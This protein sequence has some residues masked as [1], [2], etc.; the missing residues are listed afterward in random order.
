MNKD[1]K[2]RYK[3]RTKNARTPKPP[4]PKP[5]EYEGKMYVRIPEFGLCRMD[6]WGWTP[7]PESSIR[8]ES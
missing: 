2:A 7:V 3:I 4:R 6:S 5:F 1:R 8:K